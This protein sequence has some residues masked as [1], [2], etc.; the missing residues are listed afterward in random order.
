MSEKEVKVYDAEN[1]VIGRLA[2]K[3]A[4]AALLGARVAI[5]NSEKAI[6]PII[7]E[8]GL[9]TIVVQTRWSEGLF[10]ACYHGPPL[11]G[12]RPTREC[13]ASLVF[14][15]SMQNQRRLFSK[16]LSIRA[17]DRSTSR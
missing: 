7:R 10:E 17:Y 5:V 12:K 1:M 16:A 4:K 6:P 9:S 14:Q 15:R 2:S 8:R 11:A 13:N 3:V